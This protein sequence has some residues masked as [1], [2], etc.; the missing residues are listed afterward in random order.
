ME[1]IFLWI[2]VVLAPYTAYLQVKIDGLKE[3]LSTS[4]EAILA[5]ARELK[6]YG[7]PNI[8]F[9]EDDDDTLTK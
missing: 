8:V 3:E 5:M 6:S 4:S 2:L 7:S 9:V 1:N